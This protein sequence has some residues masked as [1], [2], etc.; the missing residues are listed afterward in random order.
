M[1]AIWNY[2][3]YWNW[4]ML[5]VISITIFQRPINFIFFKLFSKLNK[6]KS[7]IEK[8]FH[9]SVNDYKTGI[10]L[11][12]AFSSIFTYT[13]LIICIFLFWLFYIIKQDLSG[14]FKFC[15]ALAFLFSY[16]LNNQLLYKNDCYKKYFEKFNA[17]KLSRWNYIYVLLTYFLILAIFILTLYYTVPW[18]L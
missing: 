13:L 15:L 12:F 18:N 11:G 2:Y 6:N 17:S 16:L 8:G 3:F 10:N 5:N 14:I 4:R 1:Q 9:K 7:S